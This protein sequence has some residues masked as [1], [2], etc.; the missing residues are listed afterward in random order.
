M[1]LVTTTAIYGLLS[2]QIYLSV[3]ILLPWLLPSLALWI[4]LFPIKKV[5]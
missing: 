2:L 4:Y 3:A 1:A 5:S